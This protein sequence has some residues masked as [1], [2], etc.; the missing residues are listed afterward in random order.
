M[1]LL[2]KYSQRDLANSQNI[3]EDDDPADDDENPEQ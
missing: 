1:K 3:Q 2:K